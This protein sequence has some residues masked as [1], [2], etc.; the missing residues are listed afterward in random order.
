VNDLEQNRNTGIVSGYRA[1]VIGGSAGSFQV[2]T[3]ILSSLPVNF[4]LPVILCLHRLKHVRQGFVEALNLKSNLKVVEPDD[5][6]IIRN[7]LAYLAPANYHLYVELGNYF[8]LSTEEM[9]KFSRPS[10]DL[11]LDSASYFYKEKMIAILLSGANSD[12]ADGMKMAKKRGALTL[13]QS[14]QEAS[15]K[16]MP[17]AAISATTIDHILKTD[18]L[19]ELL[20]KLNGVNLRN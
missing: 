20:I 18:D 2:V 8:A 19:V 11:T 9:V 16:T 4:N 12:G 7:G 3:R 17:E 14:P 13:V 6:E 15:I 1:V 5:K 10:I